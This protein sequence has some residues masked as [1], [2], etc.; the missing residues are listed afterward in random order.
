MSRFKIFD[1]VAGR[2]RI[3]APPDVGGMSE[4]YRCKDIETGQKVAL[5]VLKKGANTQR[6]KHAASILKRIDHPNILAIY[7]FIEKDDE[8]YQVEEYL[9]GMTLREQLDRKNNFTI[10]KTADIVCR[11]LEGIDYLHSEGIIHQDIKPGNIFLLPGGTVK[12]IDFGLAH[13]SKSEETPWQTDLGIHGTPQYM[14]PERLDGYP[15]FSGDRY[16]A[17]LVLYEMLTRI[18]PFNIKDKRGALKKQKSYMPPPP[19]RINPIIPPELDRVVLKALAK[20][21]SERFSTSLEFKARLASASQQPVNSK[22]VRWEVILLTA[23]LAVFA[24]IVLSLIKAFY[25]IG[26]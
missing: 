17:G 19:S 20:K 24:F 14:A 26:H 10:V 7:D 21:P 12:I 8:I 2:Y 11:L 22:K 9:D 3:M 23:L 25:G 13:D 6:F 5:R 1:T 15:S 16:A 4:V 18:N